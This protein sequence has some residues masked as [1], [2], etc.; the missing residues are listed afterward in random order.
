MQM[1]TALSH[2]IENVLTA[3]ST[4]GLVA[5]TTAILRKMN[6]PK[7]A[8]NI[9]RAFSSISWAILAISALTILCVANS[10]FCIVRLLLSA[11]A[12]VSGAVLGNVLIHCGLLVYW[13][14]M[15]A[16]LVTARVCIPRVMD[17]LRL[18]GDAD[19]L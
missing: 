6:T 8:M 17:R 13:L 1:L 7:A 2:V 14:V 5:I 12:C 9:V 4:L 15:V 18:L 16:M 19:G 3:V 11:G 10:M